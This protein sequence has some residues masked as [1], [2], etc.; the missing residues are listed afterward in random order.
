MKKILNTDVIFTILANNFTVKLMTASNTKKLFVPA[1]AIETPTMASSIP[2]TPQMPKRQQDQ[3]IAHAWKEAR[4]KIL[5]ELAVFLS[6]H[7]SNLWVRTI[8][9]FDDANLQ[10]MPMKVVSQGL[11]KA[12]APFDCHGT[13]A[14][15]FQEKCCTLAIHQSKLT[16][17]TREKQ[18]RLF[19]S[20]K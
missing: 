16:L 4:K 9:L 14:Y 11:W 3:V 8:D 18:A 17:A 15:L 13:Q 2:I 6:S 7:C 5:T 20:Q 10:G 19:G 12:D 1:I